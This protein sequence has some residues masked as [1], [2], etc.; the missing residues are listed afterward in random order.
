MTMDPRYSPSAPWP[1]HPPRRAKS[2]LL[3]ALAVLSLLFVALAAGGGVAYLWW[4]SVSGPHGVDPN[5]QPGVSD[6]DAGQPT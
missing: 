5:A 2:S 4:R 1:P 6:S 3:P